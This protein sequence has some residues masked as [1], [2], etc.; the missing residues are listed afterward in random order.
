MKLLFVVDPLDAAAARG[1]H[2]A[3]RSCSRR[4]ARGYEVWICELEHLG[5]E[6]RRRGRRRARR[7]RSRS[8]RP[9]ADA[10]QLEPRV[11]A[12]ARRLR[13]RADAQGSA[14]R[15]RR[16]TRDAGSS[17]TRAARRCSST[18]RAACAS[19]TS[20]SRCCEFPHLTPPTIVT[21]V[22]ASGCARSSASRAARSWSS[23]STASAASAS[24][25]CATAIRTRARSSRRST[26]AGHALD[27]SR[28]RTCPRCV[29]GDKRIVLVDGEPI[30]AVLRVPA[31]AE[32]RGNLHV[33]GRAVTTELDARDREIVATLAPRAARARPVPRRARRDRRHADRDQRHLA[34]RHPPHR[35]RS[36][37]ATSAARCSTGSSGSRVRAP[38]GVHKSSSK[39]AAACGICGSCA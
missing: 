37:T 14:G 2:V 11:D 27:A 31:T 3:S 7:R 17:S 24:S 39:A 28:R 38:A 10:F 12:P 33:G 13:R 16:T 32:A 15:R 4:Q 22:S 36:R 20:S 1:R 25:S 6:R 9:P 26:G 30:G 19:S 23:R 8:R 5:L 34:D 35:A 18:I 29:D 21:R